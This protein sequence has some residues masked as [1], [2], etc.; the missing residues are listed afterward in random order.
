M[1]FR[2]TFR[3]LQQGSYTLNCLRC[4]KWDISSNGYLVD[5]A[6]MWTGGNNY[7]PAWLGLL[8][9]FF[10]QQK[11][12]KKRMCL[13]E[14]TI[15]YSHPNMYVGRG[16]I[17]SVPWESWIPGPALSSILPSCLPHVHIQGLFTIL[18]YRMSH[19]LIHR[20]VVQQ[21]LLTPWPKL[22]IL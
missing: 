8:L 7:F 14:L 4:W 17:K 1:P 16:I 18:Y 22:L 15:Y 6:R 5:M 20:D 19:N 11:K 21:T 3:R 9:G 10:P 12:K 13:G 2:S